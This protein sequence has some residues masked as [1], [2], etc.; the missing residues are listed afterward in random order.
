MNKALSSLGP[1]DISIKSKWCKGCRICVAICPKKVLAMDAQHKATVVNPEACNR[2]RM[3]E[4]HCP[5]FAI[6]IGVKET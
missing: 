4:T 1:S 3:C 6:E 5:D 2:C